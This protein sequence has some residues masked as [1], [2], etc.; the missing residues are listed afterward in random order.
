[1]TRSIEG[2]YSGFNAYTTN[3]TTT[4][5]LTRDDR[6]WTCPD[7]GCWCKATDFALRHSRRCDLRGEQPPVDAVSDAREAESPAVHTV[8]EIKAAA[9]EGAISAVATDDEIVQLVSAGIVTVS[10]AMNRDF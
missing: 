9:V 7:C 3:M 5:K 2:S 8:S 6:G 10:D 1:M 4:T